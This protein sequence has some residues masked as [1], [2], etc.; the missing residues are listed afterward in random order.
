MELKFNE[1]ELGMNEMENEVEVLDEMTGAGGTWNMVFSSII[2]FGVGNKGY[3]CTWTHE[4][5]SS[6]K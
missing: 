5:Q 1:M 2:S 6:C 3:V 4:C